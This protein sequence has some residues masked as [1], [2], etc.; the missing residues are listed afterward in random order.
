MS[1]VSGE[2]NRT[3][4]HRWLAGAASG[5]L[6]ASILFAFYAGFRLPN[7]WSINYYIPSFFD[8]FGRRS[9][10]GTLLYPLGSLRFDYI[11]LASLQSVVF[12]G[13]LFVV[14][15]HALLSDLRTRVLIALFFLAPTGGYLFHTIGYVDEVLYLLMFSA[16]VL[17][18]KRIGLA[19]MA[20]SLFI[21]ELAAFTTIPLY[22]AH[23]AV[24]ERRAMTAVVQGAVLATVFAV[25]FFFLQTTNAEAIAGLLK[26]IGGN[27]R[28]TPRHDY[29]EV[30][31]SELLGD[32]A[33]NYLGRIGRVPMAVTVLTAFATAAAFI[34]Q[35]AG[36]HRLLRGAIVFAA[37]L[38]PLL[39]GFLAY[40][41]YRWVFL[42]LCS[43]FVVLTVFKGARSKVVFRVVAFIFVLFTLRGYLHYFDW[44]SARPILPY[45]HLVGFFRDELPVLLRTMPLR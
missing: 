43:S 44:L 41:V 22:L 31:S 25:I 37:C 27:G 12:C 32:L 45:P 14:I 40:D 17:P 3:R 21:H 39:L 42:S 1:L 30:F 9:L 28:Y 33:R 10:L 26:Q 8:G 16:L 35:D 4:E 13:L 29:Y 24:E 38:A 2:I 5:G 34:R 6:F 36:L 15:R 19:I 18:D 20:A 11:F 7:L 23:L